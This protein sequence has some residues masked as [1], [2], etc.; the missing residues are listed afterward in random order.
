MTNT[1][2]LIIPEQLVAKWSRKYRGSKSRLEK[3]LRLINNVKAQGEGVYVVTGE[4]GNDYIVWADPWVKSSTCT[5]ED[6]KRGYY[7]K[8]K[9]AVAL[10]YVSS[11]K[12]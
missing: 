12:S 1:E 4:S 11:K 3:A 9:W 7:C 10:V 5:C 6:Y 8:H 2:R